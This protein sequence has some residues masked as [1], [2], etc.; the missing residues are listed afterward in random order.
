MSY[1][2]SA[3]GS[4]N[5]ELIQ[6]NFLL[7]K[8]EHICNIHIGSGTYK[9]RMTWFYTKNR[10]Y[11]IKFGYQV[12]HDMILSQGTSKANSKSSASG[13]RKSDWRIIIQNINIP[14]KIR[15]FLWRVCSDI[16]LCATKLYQRRL[17]PSDF[18]V[19]CHSQKETVLHGLWDCQN[20]KNIW[21]KLNFFKALRNKTFFD[22]ADVVS[23]VG[24]FGSKIQI[25]TI[26]MLS[27]VIWNRRNDLFISQKSGRGYYSVK[28]DYDVFEDFCRVNFQCPAQIRN[29]NGQKSLHHSL[30]SI[31]IDEAIFAKRDCSRMGIVIRDWNGQFY[32]ARAVVV[33]RICSPLEIEL[34]NVK[35]SFGLGV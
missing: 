31:N 14:N 2:I 18:Y 19:I 26:A 23:Y 17:I 22:F 25:Q 4:C 6:G 12:A 21:K 11:L 35:R 3:E 10:V 7:K 32:L 24:D 5:K 34:L 9:D 15:L 16:L 33:H 1:L 13:L 29:N 20:A 8:A 30:F 27:W 28:Q